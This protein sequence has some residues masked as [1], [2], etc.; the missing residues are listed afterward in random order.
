MTLP[1]KT[2]PSVSESKEKLKDR[3]RTTVAT[4]VPLIAMISTT[5]CLILSGHLLPAVNPRLG[6]PAEV[7]ELSSNGKPGDI[8][9]SIS[10][11]GGQLVAFDS[12][13][14]TARW[15]IGSRTLADVQS[16]S[17]LLQRN[18]RD[19]LL[20]SSLS[21][22]SVASQTRVILSVD[23]H[24]R[25]FHIKPILYALAEARISSYSFEVKHPENG[26]IATIFPKI[27]HEEDATLQ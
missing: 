21:N 23:Q 7:M 18:V 24:L 6:N 5:I 2:L 8:F 3:L 1:F 10:A 11:D 16:F 22:R 20:T 25:Y 26:R 13:R 17:E 9:L 4:Y 15:P 12:N 19:G 14:R 27:V